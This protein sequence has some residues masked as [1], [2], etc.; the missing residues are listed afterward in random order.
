MKALFRLTLL[1]LVTL[2]LSSMSAFAATWKHV[3]NT[4]GL[5]YDTDQICFGKRWSNAG[6]FIEPD[7]SRIFGWTKAVYT[8]ED[9][10]DFVKA[11]GDSRYYRLNYVIH[12]ITISIPDKTYTLHKSAYYAED[13][14][15][16]NTSDLEYTVKALPGSWV[17]K[18]YEDIVNYALT[19]EE[20]L[21]QHTM[22]L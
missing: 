21:T 13:G 22:S 20:I 10:V 2:L 7:P 18:L 4:E 19:N 3:N 11:L 1:M 15:L 16:L 14:T 17:E 6:P 5:Y 9:A 12:L 8:P